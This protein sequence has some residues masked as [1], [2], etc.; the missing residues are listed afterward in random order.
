MSHHP[1]AA[2]RSYRPH[3]PAPVIGLQR[4]DDG[5]YALRRTARDRLK[6]SRPA[7]RAVISVSRPACGSRLRLTA[8]RAFRAARQRA[9]VELGENSSARRIEFCTSEQAVCHQVSASQKERAGVTRPSP[10]STME[11]NG[12]ARGRGK[13]RRSAWTSAADRVDGTK[14]TPTV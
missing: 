3:C 2:D 1:I 8:C 9:T 14:A 6:V 12:R 7:V 5:A 4:L 13:C 10:C 11:T